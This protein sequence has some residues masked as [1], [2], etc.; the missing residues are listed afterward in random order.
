LLDVDGI[1]NNTQVVEENIAVFEERSLNILVA[2][3]NETNQM[4]I[5]GLIEKLGHKVQLASNG[6]ETLKALEQ[7]Q[8]FDLILM[9]C[10]MPVMDGY[11]ATRR[12]RQW[13]R[14]NQMLPVVII[15]L[16]A[17]LLEDQRDIC[18]NAGM[19]N[20]ID[21]PLDAKKLNELVRSYMF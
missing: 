19:D 4:V 1:E 9:D 6:R 12:I 21:K 13:E 8:V 11:E 15:A 16:T 17:H 20:C 18:L 14:K 3:D 10:E 2:E 5:C 7:D